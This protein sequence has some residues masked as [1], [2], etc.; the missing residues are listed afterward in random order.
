[1]LALIAKWK[2]NDD[3]TYELPDLVQWEDGTPA[4]YDD[5]FKHLGDTHTWLSNPQD[6]LEWRGYPDIVADNPQRR[7]YPTRGGRD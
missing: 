1:M 4:T 2:T 3:V 7:R 6:G 5:Y